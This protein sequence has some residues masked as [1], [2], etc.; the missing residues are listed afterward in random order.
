MT[1]DLSP[2][3]PKVDT[4]K[5]GPIL[6]AKNGLGVHICLPKLDLSYQKWTGPGCQKWTGLDLTFVV[7][8]RMLGIRMLGMGAG[9]SRELVVKSGLRQCCYNC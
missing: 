6:A 2:V 3:M 7:G 9:N 1:L 4:G 8:I 5:S